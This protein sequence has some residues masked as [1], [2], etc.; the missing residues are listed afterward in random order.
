MDYELILS[1]RRTVSL[2]VRGGKVIVR[3]PRGTERKF[4]DGLIK[5][6]LRWINNRIISQERRSVIDE[7]LSR[8]DISEIKALAKS[9]FDIKT[10]EYANIMGL[11]YSRVEISS[12]K[13]K[14]GSCN[15]K[16][17]L[18]LVIECTS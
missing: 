7:A 16:G 8:E 11:K 2:T 9:Y 14:F 6:H 17:V 1:D 4:V 15:S 3:A 12:A 13:K 18:R 10:A 5:K